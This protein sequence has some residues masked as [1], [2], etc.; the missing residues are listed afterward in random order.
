MHVAGIQ[1]MLLWVLSFLCPQ[2]SRA[3]PALGWKHWSRASG[4]WE[5]APPHPPVSKPCA[6]QNHLCALPL[7]SSSAAPHA[8][9]VR[10]TSVAP[11]ICALQAVG[12]SPIPHP[13]PNTCAWCLNCTRVHACRTLAQQTSH[14]HGLPDSLVHITGLK[15]PGQTHFLSPRSQVTAA[16]SLILVHTN[17]KPSVSFQM[18][19]KMFLC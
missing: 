11:T 14:G 8:L 4:Y 9:G 16:S 10:T 3:A 6:P 19:S 7:L 2:W 18:Q 13:G 1:N 17:S 15:P 12:C 5:E